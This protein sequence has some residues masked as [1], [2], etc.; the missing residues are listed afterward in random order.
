[1]TKNYYNRNLNFII[2]FFLYLSLLFGFFFDENLNFGAMPD[3]KYTDLP[4]VRELALDIKKTLLNYDNYGHRHSPVY[5]IFLSLL[6]KIGFSYEW[7]RFLHLNIS[8]F[9]IFFFYKCLIFK[10]DK[11]EKNLLLLFSLT[12]F[13]SPTFRS[14]AI[15]PSSRVIGLIIFLIS[16]Y[17]FLKF[18]K[19]QKKINM[20]KNIVFLIISS[21]VSPNFSV[22]IIFFL[23]HYF[24]KI[25]YKDLIYI[26]L[27]CFVCSIPAFYYI[28][29]LDIN[30]LIVRE[31]GSNSNLSNVY[32]FNLS[33]KIFIISSILFFH[34]S[35]FLINKEFLLNLVK[36]SKKEILFI[37]QFYLI[38]LYFFGY[39]IIYTGGGV[40]F[41]LSNLLF[42]NNYFFYLI[43]LISLFVLCKL[44]RNSIK[45][46]LIF[47]LLIISNIQNTIYHKYYDPLIMILF[48][49]LINNPLNYKFFEN[50]YNVFIVY[51]FSLVFIIMRLVKNNYS[52]T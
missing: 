17:E 1:M 4:V 6:R 45:N 2:F 43:T 47:F 20:W 51:S 33:D 10:F 29:I 8:L 31:P 50:R 14:L 26:L 23:Y 37:T 19:K 16:V 49:T 28:F 24:R 48:F 9:L 40:F 27:F 11:I 21:Y 18:L 3:W 39:L 25:D 41:Q 12:I 44:S 5:L 36:P 34:L 13:L 32:I 42:N 30:F 52:L 22:F 46:Y 38:N 35:P 7:I 15:W